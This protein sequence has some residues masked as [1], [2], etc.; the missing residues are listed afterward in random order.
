[1]KVEDVQKVTVILRGYDYNQV[2]TIADAMLKTNIRSMEIT[3]NS[4]DAFETAKKIVSEYKD[5]F[6]G[7]G[8]ILN[9]EHVK[10]AIEAN[11]DFILTPIILDK[12]NIEKCRKNGIVTVISALTPS[13]I[14]LVRNYNADIIKIFPAK[15]VGY[16]YAKAVKAP[17]GQKIKLMAVGG[18]NKDNAKAFMNG[19]YDYLGVGSSMFNHEDIVNGNIDNLVKSLK[20]FEEKLGVSDGE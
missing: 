5:I 9:S 18:V 4:P 3:T 7:L 17:L 11:V 20:A 8:T 13:E 19:G 12:E 1:M 6:V 10:K 14:N 15:N 16:D 2:K